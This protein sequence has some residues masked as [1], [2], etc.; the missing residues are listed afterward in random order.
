MSG[1]SLLASQPTAQTGDQTKDGWFL[2]DF[3]AFSYLLN[4]SV[5]NQT[6]LTAAKPGRL[7][8][9]Y[10]DFLHGLP[11]RNRKVVL[12]RDVLDSDITPVTLVEPA[13]MID[14]FLSEVNE[15]SLQA[16]TP[17]LD[18]TTMAATQPDDKSMSWR[19]SSSMGR[20]CG[21][22]F[23]GDRAFGLVCHDLFPRHLCACSICPVKA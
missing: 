1:T 18:T 4:G 10:C 7:V 22:V 16:V 15:A 2:S 14:R 12:R 11:D 8:E 6:W 5:A 20:A 17:E 19:L 9:K 3:Y 23:A 13:K 21:S